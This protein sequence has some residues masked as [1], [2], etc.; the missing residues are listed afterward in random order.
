MET[1][2][3]F[4]S[5]HFRYRVIA[6]DCPEGKVGRPLMTRYALWRSRRNI[7]FDGKSVSKYA[8][9]LH[10]FHRSDLDEFHD[11][12]W[13][14]ITFL[15][16]S[17]YWEHTP[18]CIMC[19]DGICKRF[20]PNGIINRRTWKRRFSILYRPATFQHYVEVVKPT[21]TL[22]FRFPEVRQWGFIIKGAWVH[23]RDVENSKSRS[24][25]EDVSE[26]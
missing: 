8:L 15:F 6:P 21:W 5:R 13:A 22:V 23:W 1:I 18:D 12:P 14:F 24:I 16:H 9:F 4:L 17:G 7:V 26:V 10:K 3:K 19:Q 20:Q 2:N 11:H 25:C